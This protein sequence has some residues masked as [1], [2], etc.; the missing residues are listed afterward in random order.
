ARRDSA[1]VGTEWGASSGIVEKL[2][3]DAVHHTLH[4]TG[5]VARRESPTVFAVASEIYGIADSVFLL[6][7]RSLPAIL[8]VIPAARTHEFVSNT[9]KIDP[10]MRELMRE[11]WTRVKQFTIVDFLPLV[12]RAIGSI[13]FGRQRM[14]WRTEPENV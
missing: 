13:T 3:F 7:I 11:Q 9:A 14:R 2:T 6:H 12:G 4:P 8:E 1:V 10:H 5:P